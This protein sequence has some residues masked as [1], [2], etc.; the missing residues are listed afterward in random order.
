MPCLKCNAD[1]A[2]VYMGRCAD[3]ERQEIGGIQNPVRSSEADRSI[4]YL[5]RLMPVDD[6]E[7]LPGHWYCNWLARWF[8]TPPPAYFRLQ[9]DI[10]IA[11]SIAN[12][13]SVTGPSWS[14][15][16]RGQQRIKNRAN[17]A[18]SRLK[19][20]LETCRKVHGLAVVKFWTPRN[21]RRA[22]KLPAARRR[23]AA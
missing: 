14:A 2:T 19:R 4:D 6:R 3:C 22:G 10:R 7:P 12:A 13:V 5:I 8:K 18:V 20:Q 11:K 9:R 1:N 15:A 23:L 17:T 21:G 16:R